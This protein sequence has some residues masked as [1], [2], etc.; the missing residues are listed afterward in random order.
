MKWIVALA[1][2]FW[3]HPILALIALVLLCDSEDVR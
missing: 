2:I 3:G 1:L